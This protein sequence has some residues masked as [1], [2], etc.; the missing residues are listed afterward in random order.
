MERNGPPRISMDI[1]GS[2]ILGVISGY[3]QFDMSFKLAVS[4][5]RARH[6]ERISKII[7]LWEI[8]LK[9]RKTFNKKQ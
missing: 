7:E 9:S 3:M 8:K 2:Q 1:V 6:S 4:F 5:E